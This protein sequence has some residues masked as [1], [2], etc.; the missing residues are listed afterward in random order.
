MRQTANATI[1]VIDK[2]LNNNVYPAMFQVSH[3][4]CRRLLDYLISF[5]ASKYV[6][7]ENSIEEIVI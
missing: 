5:N 3:S 7:I 1:L 4:K 2:I 6:F